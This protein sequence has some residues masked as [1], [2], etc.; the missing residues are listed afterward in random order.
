MA[1][2]DN[3]QSPA[4]SA[5]RVTLAQLLLLA[6]AAAVPALFDATHEA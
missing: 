5:D 4:G 1:A 6:V 3:A 2:V